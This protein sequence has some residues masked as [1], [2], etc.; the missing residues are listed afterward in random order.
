MPGSRKRLRGFGHLRQHSDNDGMD[1]EINKDHSS[2]KTESAAGM[3]Q[4]WGLP[5][6]TYV[7]P[8]IPTAA[9]PN[10]HRPTMALPIISSDGS[11]S[12]K[13]SIIDDKPMREHTSSSAHSS[14]ASASSGP[15]T[16]FSS[17][18]KGH[19]NAMPGQTT[20]PQ[21]GKIL[22]NLPLA[23]PEPD[24]TSKSTMYQPVP[25]HWQ[26]DFP[27]LIPKSSTP[28]VDDVFGHISSVTDTD[29]LFGHSSS[30][31][32][33]MNP[34]IEKSSTRL[35]KQDE[36]GL[37]D[38]TTASGSTTRGSEMQ[39]AVNNLSQRIQTLQADY[40]DHHA[41]TPGSVWK[42]T[43]HS[44]HQGKK[45]TFFEK[46]PLDL[47]SS[48]SQGPSPHDNTEGKQLSLVDGDEWPSSFNITPY[49]LS[50][51]MGGECNTSGDEKLDC[52]SLGPSSHFTGTPTSAMSRPTSSQSDWQDEDTSG[53]EKPRA[54]SPVIPEDIIPLQEFV[55][56]VTTATCAGCQKPIALEPH[57][58]V[59]MTRTWASARGG[60]YMSLRG[61][62]KIMAS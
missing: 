39:T 9:H 7:A 3:N 20:P 8:K 60:A 33:F 55:K 16:N 10:D 43:M 1:Q 35:F 4:F 31:I 12:M 38:D 29:R 25:Y 59:E 22:S 57:N 32:D 52:S 47:M 28:P 37:I 49:P 56:R 19:S 23:T 34:W 17:A 14:Q 61:S 13:S 58:V 46:Y 50:K 21:T 11:A 54:E 51:E 53:Q 44:D 40:G 42:P 15:F 24:T 48:S 26:L 5:K 45:P 18:R 30:P 2:G 62:H 36:R 27:T 41:F 6:S